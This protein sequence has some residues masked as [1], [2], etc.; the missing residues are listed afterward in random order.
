MCT[1]WTSSGPLQM[2]LGTASFY[3]VFIVGFDQFD[4]CLRDPSIA[5]RRLQ[6]RFEEN[7]WGKC[8]RYLTQLTRDPGFHVWLH[9]RLLA[10]G[11]LYRYPHSVES[12]ALGCH[13]G[14]G[15][16]KL[17]KIVVADGINLVTFQPLQSLVPNFKYN[18]VQLITSPTDHLHFTCVGVLHR[19]SC[20]KLEEPSE[21]NRSH[22]SQRSHASY[23]SQRNRRSQ[24][25]LRQVFFAL[26]EDVQ[27]V[28]TIHI[29]FFN[30][31]SILWAGKN[32][33]DLCCAVT[34][35]RFLL[36][37]VHGLTYH[38]RQCCV[39]LWSGTVEDSNSDTENSQRDEDDEDADETLENPENPRPRPS[40][41]R[42][43]ESW[44]VLDEQSVE[45]P[46]AAK[47]PHVCR[48]S[49]WKIKQIEDI[50]KPHFQQ[51]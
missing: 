44:I 21:E 22:I 41:L 40:R 2:C 20:W 47:G 42:N 25:L 38:V 35:P 26:C 36:K 11:L 31:V 10:P 23:R 14:A 51:I 43:L 30:H 1:G 19:T 3:G 34:T 37:S 15:A 28:M 6:S 5:H 9:V 18:E 12:T 48:D 33:I 13:H 27:S 16:W 8:I 7:F 24:V 39:V 17:M 4:G 32:G 49:F 45:P 50:F 29:T 46:N